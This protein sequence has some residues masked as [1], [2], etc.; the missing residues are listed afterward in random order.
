M[1]L[2]GDQSDSFGS[3]LNVNGIVHLSGLGEFQ[4]NQIDLPS[5]PYALRRSKQKHASMDVDEGIDM[6]EDVKVLA[7]CDPSKQVSLRGEAEV[8][9]MDAEQTWIG[10][11]K[12]KEADANA[13]KVKGM[14]DASMIMDALQEDDDEWEDM[15]DSDDDDD[16]YGDYAEG[17]MEESDEDVGEESDSEFVEGS[18]ADS[19]INT[20]RYDDQLDL[21][22]ESRQ[23]DKYKEKRENEMFPD[24]MDT[25]Q[26]INARE[27]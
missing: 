21:E 4:M 6:E 27:S 9:P 19:N 5:D 3:Q 13:R 12:L 14:G 17:K 23:F 20:D 24:E 7:R 2:M 26:D 11:D 8:D 18:V 22:E 16:G 1:G 15:E 10:E 25:P